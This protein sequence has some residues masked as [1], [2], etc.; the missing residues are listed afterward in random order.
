MSTFFRSRWKWKATDLSLWPTNL[1]R[2]SAIWICFSWIR[3][4][5]S[6]K[7]DYVCLLYLNGLRGNSLGPETHDLLSTVSWL[8]VLDERFNVG[9]CASYIRSSWKDSGKHIH[10][11]YQ[12]SANFH[13]SLLFCQFEFLSVTIVGFSFFNRVIPTVLSTSIN[14]DMLDLVTLVKHYNVSRQTA[15][16]SSK[17]GAA[18]WGCVGSLTGCW[19][20]QLFSCEICLFMVFSQNPSRVYN[21]IMHVGFAGNYLIEGLE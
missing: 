14:T 20:L 3:K 2:D 12:C 17:L 4:E 9:S 8:C 7:T 5:W 15:A 21:I 1:G 16:Q 18:V 19:K 13:L 6:G 10:S 11:I